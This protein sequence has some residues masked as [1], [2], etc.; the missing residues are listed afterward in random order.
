[1]SK[2]RFTQEQIKELLKNPNVETCSEKSISYNK[3]FKVSVINKY[4]GGLPAQEIFRQ[5]GFNIDLIGREVPKNCLCSWNKILRTKGLKYLST[6]TRGRGNSGGRPKTNWSNEKEKIK[7]LEAQVAY[8]KAEND[9]LA[10]L[11]KKSLN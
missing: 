8:L 11:R 5:A 4:Q 7:Y 3:K 1:M 10:K 9:F 2:R 6:E